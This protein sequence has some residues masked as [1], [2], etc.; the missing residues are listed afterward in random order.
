MTSAH[1]RDC[2]N[3]LE[4]IADATTHATIQSQVR[5]AMETAKNGLDARDRAELKEWA[6]SE[7]TKIEAPTQPLATQAVDTNNRRRAM[8]L[9][10]L[11]AL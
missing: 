11:E 4:T 2:K 8:L 6:Q 1:V 7:L 10:V 9:E 3:A 5:N